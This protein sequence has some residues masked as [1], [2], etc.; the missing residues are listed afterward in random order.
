MKMIQK[1]RADKLVNDNTSAEDQKSVN[2]V[3]FFNIHAKESQVKILLQ[4]T[5]GIL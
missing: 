5:V 2:E 4:A 1:D 3:S